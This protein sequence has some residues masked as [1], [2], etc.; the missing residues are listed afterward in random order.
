MNDADNVKGER[1]FMICFSFVLY[2][3]KRYEHFFDFGGTS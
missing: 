1:N 2:D 3:W